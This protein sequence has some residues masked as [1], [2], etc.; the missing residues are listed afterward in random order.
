MRALVIMI[1]I[2]LLASLHVEAQETGYEPKQLIVSFENKKDGVLDMS[3]GRMTCMFSTVMDILESYNATWMRRLYSGDKGAQNI[4]L[5][6][7]E[8]AMDVENAIAELRDDPAVKSAMRNYV[9]E[10]LAEPN[11]WYYNFDYHFPGDPDTTEDQWYL[12]VMQADKA[13]DI[14]KGRAD[15]TIGILDTGVDFYHQDLID[16]IWVNPGE[17][18]DH[19]GFV[20]DADD[21]NHQ[22]DDNNGL[23]DDL[24]GWAFTS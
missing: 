12:K 19:D 1:C 6:E 15:I 22:D 2:C 21:I 24:I 9:V 11:D 8:S 18:L 20:W 16:N 13:W 5:I 14:E 4:Y 7:L 3:N 23:I 17:D 10:F